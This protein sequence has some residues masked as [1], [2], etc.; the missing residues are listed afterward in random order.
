ML[1]ETDRLEVSNRRGTGPWFVV[2]ERWAVVGFEVGCSSGPQVYVRALNVNEGYPISTVD[3][4]SMIAS[5]DD[6]RFEQYL[7]G[8]H[9]SKSAMVDDTSTYK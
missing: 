5:D 3:S 6:M 7:N 4:T 1:L 9:I 2:A 8:R